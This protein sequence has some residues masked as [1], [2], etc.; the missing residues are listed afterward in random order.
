MVIMK[1]NKIIGILGLCTIVGLFAS[2]KKNDNPF[3]VK[4]DCLIESLVLD[5]VYSGVVDHASATVTVA[6]P[7]VHDDH[8]MT[9]TT[10]RV[11][12]GATATPGEGE[13]LNMTSTNVIHVENGNVYRDYQVKVKHDEARIIAFTLNDLYIGIID[14]VAHTITVSVPV[15]TDI[16]TLIPTIKTTDGATVSPNAG[17]PCDFTNPVDFTV[18]FNTASTTYK[19]T[20]KEK[21]NPVVLYLGLAETVAQLNP[22]EQEAVNWMLANV[23]NSDYASFSD[24]AAGRVVM[25]DCKVI[26]WHFHKDGGMEGK[27]AFEANAPEAV[28]FAVL[29][30]LKDFYQA[31][32]SFL[33]TR[34]A[35]NLPFYLG[36]N[37]CFP[38]NA[39]GGKEAEAE[40]V[41]S[42][43]EFA[44]TGHTDHALWQNLTMNPTALDHVYT[45]D[46]GYKITNSTAQYHIGTD[47]G[48]YD[49][50]EA[51]HEKT[52]AYDIAGGTDAVVVWEYRRTADHGAII[53]IGSGCY[54]WYTIADP[55]E[56]TSYYHENIA[57]ITQNAFNYLKGE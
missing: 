56:Y 10:L 44:I 38:N 11:S 9:I 7:E 34:Y 18:T 49:N 51:F 41:G 27:G 22:E 14:Q 13:Q 40:R 12:D 1:L 39:W 53:C 26:W 30:K 33:L 47:W 23:E 8:L 6:V 46:E 54:D 57:K 48:G 15:G 45:C 37:E 32:G 16:K 50:R 4:G 20:V 43:W 29:D 36:E 55:S 17:I 52:G 28:D 24:L 42:P 21:G 2:C 35:V 3:N 19:V 5:E 25:T 31:G